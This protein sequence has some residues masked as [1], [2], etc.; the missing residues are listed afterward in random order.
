M[1]YVV[2]KAGRQDWQHV[3]TAVTRGRSRVYVIAEEAHLRSA[4]SRNNVRRKTRLKHFLQDWL[5]SSE[6][7]AEGASPSK[8]SEDGRCP[9]TPPPASPFPADA[10]SG[11]SEVQAS[12]SAFDAFAGFAA[13]SGGRGVPFSGETN[14]GGDPA[15]PRG[16]KRACAVADESPSK[17][18]MVRVVFS[19]AQAV[20]VAPCSC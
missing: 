18:L 14:A 8:G 7:P 17:V 12:A 16:S 20:P 13:A 3:Y 19:R 5:S 11:T 6:S 9:S 4:I 15:Q 1:V 10:H 2:G